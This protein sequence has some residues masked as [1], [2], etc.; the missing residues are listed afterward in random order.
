MYFEIT[1]RPTSVLPNSKQISSNTW[2]HQLHTAS[3]QGYRLGDHGGNFVT[4]DHVD[5]S[6]VINFSFY[7]DFFLTQNLAQGTLLTN[8]DDSGS[9]ISQTVIAA[10]ITHNKI[11][12]GYYNTRSM[13]QPKSNALR[14][15]VIAKIKNFLIENILEIKKHVGQ[16][17]IAY[18]GGLDSSTVA[19]LAHQQKI[20]FTAVVSQ[21]FRHLWPNLPFDCRYCDL[22]PAPGG[23]KFAWPSNTVDHFYQIDSCVGGFYGDV[24]VLHHKDL[25]HQSKRLTNH[26]TNNS[27]HNDTTCALPEF[28]SITQL[29]ASVVKIQLIPQFRHWFDN[30]ETPDPYR[31]PRVV[32]TVMQLGLWNLVEQFDSAYIQRQI[33]DGIDANCVDFVCDHK[34][35]YTKFNVN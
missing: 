19:W 15:H 26:I 29:N 1:T 18:S 30:Y 4:F 13:L 27:Y 14:S 6:L 28:L 10:Q 22:V 21:D 8:I 17:S 25:Y 34:N 31:D 5:L 3:M 2:L 7:K 32:E 11:N 20:K 16:L 35:D 9:K 12:F 33:L 23:T 24:A